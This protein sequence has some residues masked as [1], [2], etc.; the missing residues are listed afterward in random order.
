MNGNKVNKKKRLCT[1]RK[2]Y[3]GDRHK[4]HRLRDRQR[5]TDRQTDRYEHGLGQ[6]Q[7]RECR[8]EGSKHEGKT[9][10][11]NERKDSKHEGKTASTKERQQA[12]RKGSKHEGKERQ[13]ARRKGSKHEGKERQ[14]AG[15]KGKAKGKKGRTEKIFSAPVSEEILIFPESHWN[16]S[17]SFTSCLHFWG[18][19]LPLVS[20]NPFPSLMTSYKIRGEVSA[21]CQ[22]DSI[23]RS[24]PI[25]DDHACPRQTMF[26]KLNLSLWLNLS[27][28]LFGDGLA[29]AAQIL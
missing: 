12:R 7:T 17:F 13:Q 4:V 20:V 14:Q 25:R 26:Y 18:R 16:C 9:A 8:G 22:N 1:K 3:K 15:R 24:A 2:Q 29:P 23:G 28:G 21:I 5:D 10:S 11:T 19:R 6:R 27:A